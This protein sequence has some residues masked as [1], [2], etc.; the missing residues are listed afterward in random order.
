MAERLQGAKEAA[1]TAEVLFGITAKGVEAGSFYS[2][3]LS[4]LLWP[5]SRS[6]S[7]YYDVFPRCGCVGFI[8]GGLLGAACGLW[9][10]SKMS[11][12]DAVE[13][14]ARTHAAESIRLDQWTGVGAF[15]GGVMATPGPGSVLFQKTTPFGVRL[16]GGISIGAAV[17]IL[18]FAASCHPYFRPYLKYLPQTMQPTQKTSEPP[19]NVVGES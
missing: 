18:V 3:L 10:T 16:G 13:C 2:V 5:F 8:G 1:L 12:D 17:G 11:Y 14:K 9:V 15:S 4:P 19:S 7:W 6:R